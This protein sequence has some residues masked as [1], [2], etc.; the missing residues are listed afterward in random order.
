MA[1]I[2]LHFSKQKVYVTQVYIYF[3]YYLY[4]FW[5]GYVLRQGTVSQGLTP[6]HC[7]PLIAHIALCKSQMTSRVLR[8]MAAAMRVHNVLQGTVEQLRWIVAAFLVY[9]LRCCT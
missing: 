1:W 5:H 3:V 8:H 2:S 9:V 7:I 6:A 4:P